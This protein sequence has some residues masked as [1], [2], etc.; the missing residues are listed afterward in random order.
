[1]ISTESWLW[2]DTHKIIPDAVRNQTTAA[3]NEVE[4]NG[5]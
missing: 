5:D 1:M 3:F 2:L 4:Q